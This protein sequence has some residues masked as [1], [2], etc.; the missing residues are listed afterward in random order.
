ML[1]KEFAMTGG[2]VPL[3]SQG[4]RLTY[5]FKFPMSRFGGDTMNVDAWVRFQGKEG[6]ERIGSLK[7]VK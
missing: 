3:Q 1:A 7:R 5:F 2:T 6:Q 4:G